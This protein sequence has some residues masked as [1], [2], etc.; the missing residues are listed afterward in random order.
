VRFKF[1]IYISFIL[2]T[3]DSFPFYKYGLG[4]AK[5]LSILPIIVF[6]FFNID[7]IVKTKYS[8]REYI[9]IFIVTL[10][11]TI[12]FSKGKFT[13]N[14]MSEFKASCSM[15]IVYL[16]SVLSFKLYFKGIS[17][18]ELIKGLRYI[19]KSFNI[20]IFFAILEIIYF[21][22]GKSE[23][24]F[25][26]F[27]IFLRDTMYVAGGRVQL[28]FG[29]PSSAAFMIFGLL[30]PVILMLKKLGY[31]FKMIEKIKVVSI[32]AI[33]ILV[34]SNTFYLI[35]IVTLV[36]YY[37]VK[38]SKSI[39]KMVSL[40]IVIGIIFGS[41]IYINNKYENSNSSNR[42]I[43]M[44]VQKNNLE[45]DSSYQV[46]KALIDTS[47]Y[48]WRDNPVIGSGWGYF[49][50]GYR[51]NFY[52]IN[53]LY[54]TNWEL[55]RKL[56]ADNLQSYSIYT[57]ALSEGGVLGVFWL[58][59]IFTSAFKNCKKNSIL[60]VAFLVFC[61]MSVQSIYIYQVNMIFIMELIK[62]KRIRELII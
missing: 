54:K 4:S 38:G 16:T 19:F 44:I 33:C 50:Y 7:K 34:K 8:V 12:S 31:E 56:S 25:K 59:L 20:S 58:I 60:L 49:K 9:E 37:A 48:T 6:F 3:F 11:L 1:L 57:T 2:I 5:P 28:N 43:N 53:D 46:R 24:L 30:V 35:G 47:I 45:N 51:E 14:D 15:F 32:F 62:S 18:E 26:V 21:Y 27:Q 29:E 39:K 23:T 41:Y 55:Q 13:Y 40:T 17:K 52:K 22:A 61:V 10:L 36:G 42:F